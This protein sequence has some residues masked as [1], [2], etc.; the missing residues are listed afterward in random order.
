MDDPFSN[1]SFKYGEIRYFLLILFDLVEGRY[2]IDDAVYPNGLNV[3]YV[4]RFDFIGY[5]IGISFVDLLLS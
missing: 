1:L 4:T 2:I 5:V 3:G